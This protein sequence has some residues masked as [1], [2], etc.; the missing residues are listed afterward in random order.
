MDL[1]L[2]KTT[3]VGAGLMG[4]QI[5][6]VLALGSKRTDLVGRRQ[7]SLDKAVENLGSYAIFCLRSPEKTG[8]RS[9]Q[10][11]GCL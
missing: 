3:V 8:A 6:L 2:D 10:D 11:P 9:K 4:S 1:F 5:G 7:E